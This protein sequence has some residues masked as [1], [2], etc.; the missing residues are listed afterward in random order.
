MNKI[1]FEIKNIMNDSVEKYLPEVSFEE[2]E[3]NG[4]KVVK[5]LNITI[6]ATEEEIFYLAVTLKNEADNEKIWD[7]NIEGIDTDLMPDEAKIRTFCEHEPY[8]ADMRER[9]LLMGK[10]GY[11]SKYSGC[12]YL[13]INAV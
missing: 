5:E 11:A 6:E 3:D 10:I 4:E 8:Y 1:L 13:F 9:K 2:L 12:E 7:Y